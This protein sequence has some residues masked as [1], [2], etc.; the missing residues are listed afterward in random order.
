MDKLN[1]V[2]VVTILVV[3]CGV[4]LFSRLH[5]Y[6]EPLER[7]LTTY[8][9]IAHEMLA[10]KSL[11][12]EL[13]DHKP[14]AIHVTYALAELIAGYGRDSIFLMNVVTAIATLFACYWAGSAVNGG[15]VGG[16][17]AAA[18]WAFTSGSLAFEGNQP[19]TEVFLNVFLTTGF[20]ILVCRGERDLGIHSAVLTGL[21]F[22][23][24]SVYKQIVIAQAALLVA[25]YCAFCP[26]ESRKKAITSGVVIGGVGLVTWFLVC[27]YFFARGSGETF[28][29]A[30]FR[31]N[32]YYSRDTTHITFNHAT[33]AETVSFEMVAI[34][35]S[36]AALSVAGAVYGLIFGPRRHW[37][38]LCAL[39]LGTEIAILLPGRFFSHYYQLW[40][41]P[42]AIGAGWAVVSLRRFL[43]LTWSSVSYLVGAAT[44]AI[45][46][47]VQLPDLFIPASAWSV[48]KYGN[49]FVETDELARKFDTLLLQ[50][51]TFYEWGNESGFYFTSR[52]RPPSGII[53]ASPMLTGPLKAKLSQRLIDDLNRAKPDLIV[54]DISTMTLTDHEHPV[55]NWF[56]QNY[57][58]FARTD[59]FLLFARK[60]SRLDDRLAE[61]PAN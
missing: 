11:Y 2:W 53:S 55:L 19:N 61:R 33:H 38:Y 22:A 27:A 58:T 20:A 46:I 34:I 48:K 10:G 13:W 32:S 3:L 49:I 43:P 5:T 56:K 25:A 7:D 51:E 15:R 29:D 1:K 36:M 37:I 42:L 12:S 54:A 24:A 35:V 57:N 41:P 52:R 26:P 16:C 45:V 28:I 30:V 18:L 59:E 14:P 9:V 44:C 4:I 60:G 23:I 6:N 17:F 31:Y 39:A 21:L 50:D 47:A 8:A 40:L